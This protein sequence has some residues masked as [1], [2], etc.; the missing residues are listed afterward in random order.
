MGY[1]DDF[2]TKPK[3]NKGNLGT[4][5]AVSLVSALIGSATTVAL[6]PMMINSNVIET[7]SAFADSNNTNGGS[8]ETINV[9]VQT[10]VVEAV[11]KVKPAVVG[12]LNLQKS[13]DFFGRS[14][15]EQTAG[16]GSGI[17]FDDKGHIITNNH[18]VEGADTVEVSLQD[19]KRIK[20]KVLGA[21]AM[22]DLAVLEVDPNDVKGLTPAKFGNSESLNIGEP[23][24]AIGNPLG[25]KF[26]QSVT[27][28][29]ISATKR[30]MPIY[31]EKGSEVFSQNVLQT[32]AA[33]NPGNSGGALVNIKGELIGINSAKISSTGVEG[34]GF[35]IPINEA[36]PILQQL[37]EKGEIVRP[38]MGITPVA[39]SE[40]PEGYRGKVPVEQGIYVYQVH[41]NAKKAGLAA[42]D[43]IVKIDGEATEDPIQ[44]RKILYKKKPGDKVKVEFY[45]DSELKTVEM[46]LAKP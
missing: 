12:V 22:T 32:D 7:K 37:M 4:W 3:K 25:L 43:V 6:V 31:D 44:L 29:V 28:G 46:T 36:Q 40:V 10:G 14:Q 5:I 39:L 30:E 45:H 17:L 13:R 20:A 27:V 41:E 24:I 19:G 38:V 8:K 21:D 33:I 23:A 1:Y 15:D 18:V 35:A 26:A 9:D 34:I 2:D 11:N 16:T 42:G